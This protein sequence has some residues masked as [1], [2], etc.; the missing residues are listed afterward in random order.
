[1]PEIGQTISHY[2]II[3]KL[4]QGG[5]GEVFLAHD[6]SLDRSVALKFLPDIFS[7]DPE[8]LARFEREA[9]L[10]ASLNHPNIAAIHGL[11]E[12]GGKRFLVLE[13]VEGETLAQRIAKGPLPV[14]E[15]L[16]VCRQIAE[17]LEA[18][19]D[20]G[21]I[22]RDLKPANV[23]I[24][25]EGKVKVLD[26]GL[27]KAFHDEPTA[28]ELSHS[29]TLTDQMTR[30]GVILGT[31]AYMSPEQA[32]GKP[33]DKRADI[34][35]FGCVLY[36]CL[37]A[38]APFKGETVTETV[39][40][41]LEGTLD[42]NLLPAATPRVA[43]ELL[44]RC[45]M[46]D[47]RERLHDIADARI[48]IGETISLPS[49]PDTIPM[50][51]PAHAWLLGGL[52]GGLLV[53]AVALVLWYL[54]PTPAAMVGRY[55]I[56]LSP[57]LMLYSMRRALDLE[58]PT[59]TA[60]AFAQDGS[61]IV[62]IAIPESSG[63]QAKP[64]I[65]LRRMDKLDAEPVA[66]TEGGIS[67]FLS[68]DDRWIGF[69]EGGMLKKVPIEGGIPEK[70]CNAAKF[71]GADWGPDNKIVF[72]PDSARG[73]SIT[74]S[75]GN[76]PDVLTVPDPAKDE[77]SHR[78]PHYL[79]D[80]KG[81]LFTVMRHLRD[82]QPYL[83]YLDLRTRKSRVV[84][85]D[86]A[87]GRYVSSGHLV[88][89][90]QG[91]LMAV[92]FDLDRMEAKGKIKS[93]VENVMQAQNIVNS[94]YNTAAGQY[95]VTAS[96]SLAY[97]FGGISPNQERSLVRVD[98]Q[99][100]SQPLFD[101]RAAFFAPRF[102][103]DGRQIAYFTLG[104]ES[105]VW[106]YDLIRSTPS[107]FSIDGRAYYVSWMPP[108]G[109][110]LVFGWAKSGPINL[111]AQP[112]NRS[113]PMERLTQSKYEQMPGSFSPDGSILVF[114]EINPETSS[115]IMLLEIKGRQVTPFLATE[116]DETYPEVAPNGRWLAYTSNETGRNEV[117][118]QPFPI[119]GA[120]YQISNA[121]GIQ[122]IWSKDM[123]RLFYRQGDQVWSVDIDTNHG[124]SPG[125]P[126]L[127]FEQPGFGISIPMRCWN[128]LPDGQ[129]FLM[130]KLDERK[131]T[132][133]TEIILVHNWFEELK[134]LVPTGK[135]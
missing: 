111:Y 121:G 109:K 102:S 135:K 77:M 87:D 74:S 38:K 100:N 56:K 98:Y 31:A 2:R 6:T 42:W 47:P 43:K 54:R 115:D 126:E 25:P 79:P 103:P 63:F 132:P 78:L 41:I 105:Q 117:W 23:K 116:A 40:K 127:K 119:K 21:V 14:D 10:L 66:G 85:D 28:A 122:P 35:A 125:K 18:A 128:L 9:K 83:A 96:G 16:D 84:M 91:T 20:K 112:V 73:L 37:T 104:S 46:K 53:A 64:R 8:R 51:K 67:V 113:A 108:D 99:G 36:E 124:F 13:L 49:L 68:P 59:R 70:L 34:W 26:F 69:W 15:A 30:P 71:F 92:A 123:R 58:R 45:L 130:V 106:I 110:T 4:G 1:M 7:G 86:A 57:N 81:V 118:V 22:H 29:P 12:A 88:F 19:H 24:T 107:R 134:R 27:A 33:V 39:A 61:F 95:D 89:L 3:E 50:H 82:A 75:E 72:S 48:E 11:E 62:F 120:K 131:P 32:R 94:E 129:G 133:V 93:V 114:L 90:R 80:G 17:G 60:M 44:R 52:I 65:Y 5:M 55:S 101:F 76:A 97:V